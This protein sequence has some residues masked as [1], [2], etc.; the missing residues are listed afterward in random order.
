[1]EAP[2]G[3]RW[4][5]AIA[6]DHTLQRA[7]LEQ[8]L[9]ADEGFEM[10]FSGETA[11][12]LMTW[13]RTI[14]ARSRPHLIVLDLLVDRQPSVDVEL[15]KSLLIS[16]VR[17]LVCSALSSP[18]LVR[19]VLRAG[20]TG[21]VAKR[22]SEADVLAACRAVAEGGRWMTP[23]LSAVIDRDDHRPKLSAQEERSLVLYASGL[24]IGELGAAM[25]ISPETAKQ[26]LDRVRKKYAAFGLPIRTKIDFGRIAWAEGYLD[27]LVPAPRVGPGQ[28]RAGQ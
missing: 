6:E 20:V 7:R 26:Y 22:D 23:E 9:E 17:I 15:V 11:P 25:N 13:L 21:V 2:S 10:V 19:R 28:H 18:V 24:T 12:E 1:M 27:P 5:V 3:T 16:G 8:L 4:R 14:P